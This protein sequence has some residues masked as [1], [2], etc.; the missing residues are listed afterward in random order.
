MGWLQPAATDWKVSPRRVEGA[1]LGL[2]CARAGARPRAPNSRAA[3]RRAPRLRGLAAEVRRGPL[4]PNEKY[5]AGR[6][7]GG[8]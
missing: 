3:R 4:F 6:A 7:I 5:T 8:V 1:E 2:R